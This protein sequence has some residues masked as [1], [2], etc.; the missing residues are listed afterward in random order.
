MKKLFIDVMT[1]ICY[2][3]YLSVLSACQSKKDK[4]LQILLVFVLYPAMMADIDYIERLFNHDV[5]CYI[6]YILLVFI[7]YPALMV[8]ND[9]ID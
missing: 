2:H 1:A 9:Y 8:G 3:I 4:I 5:Y 7:L 6:L